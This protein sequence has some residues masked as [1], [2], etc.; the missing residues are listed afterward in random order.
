MSPGSILGHPVFRTEDPRI[1]RGED[2]YVDDLDLPDALHAVFVRSTAAHARL[3]GIDTSEAAA[4]PGVAGVFTGAD[5]DLDP[6]VPMPML[7]EAMARPPLARD[8]VRFVGEAVAVVVAGTRSAAMDAAGEVV[9]DYDPLPAVVDPARAGADDSPVLFPD[10]G[11]NAAVVFDYGR[12]PDIFDGADIVVGGRFLNQRVAPVPLEVHGAAAVPEDDDGVPGLTLW[13]S[14]Q[15][16]AS[17]REPMAKL[18]GLDLDRVRIVCPAVGGG[19]G[20]KI[21][22]IPEHVVLG[23]LARRLGRTVRWV[24]TRSESLM[25]MTHGRGQ[26]QDVEIGARSDGTLVGLRVEITG[27]CGAYPGVGAIM[28]MFTHNMVAGVYRIPK[29]DFKATTFTTNKTPMAPYRGAGRPEATALVERAMDLLA[30]ELGLDP[31]EVRRRNLIPPDAFPHTT[32]TGSTYDSGDYEAA[33]DMVLGLAGYEELRAEQAK[34]RAAGDPV[35]MGIGVSVYVEVTGSVPIPEYASVQVERDGSVTAVTGTVPNGQGHETAFA[36]IVSATLG[37]PMEV[38]RVVHSDT[39]AV[40]ESVG[41]FG[42]RSLQYGGSSILR[43]AEVVLERAKA[44]AAELLEAAPADIV[45]TDDGRVGVAG[46]PAQ[47]LSWAELASAADEPLAAAEKWRQQ[48]NTF[49]FGAH[50]A[51]VDVD[52]ETG[53]VALR[54]IVAVDDCGRILNPILVTGQ[55]HGGLAQGIAQALFE[56]VVHDAD[57][58][59]LTTTLADYLFPSAADLPSYET[60][61]TETPTPLNPLGVK[62]VGESGTIGSTPAVQSA[63]VDALVHLGVRHIDMPASPEKVWRAINQA[64]AD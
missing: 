61:H 20:A 18:V 56:E 44:R 60:A 57:G 52:T 23:A 22:L 26:I 4:M 12:Q 35:A 9:V 51:V 53:S 8:T 19:F 6:I 38:V 49:P 54:R 55:V 40:P 25:C 63:V 30:L 36:Q 13:C 43:S 21:G 16:P 46:S 14:N 59:P 27:D 5:L 37:V 17:M 48:A 10:H 32:A 1:L 58:M 50:V 47:A 29:V 2:R 28:P 42:S 33:L 39:A 7:P 3:V 11:T 34:R 15:N 31:I 64:R 62:G 41:T 45:L 24:E